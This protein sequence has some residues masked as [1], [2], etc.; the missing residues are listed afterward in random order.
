LGDHGERIFI[1]LASREAVMALLRDEFEICDFCVYAENQM[2]VKL[3][4]EQ[5]KLLM[6]NA[7]KSNLRSAEEKLT[8][9]SRTNQL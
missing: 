8:H 4:P 1:G 7:E 2:Q 6:K 3:F 5:K 9:D